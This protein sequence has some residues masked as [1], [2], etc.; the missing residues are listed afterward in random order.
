MTKYD[1]KSEGDPL[2]AKIVDLMNIS[3]PGAGN[4]KFLG[5]REVQYMCGI[6]GNRNPGTATLSMI[7]ARSGAGDVT[8]WVPL[9]PFKELFDDK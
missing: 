8:H 9:N 2:K 6:K 7:Q 1:L 3:F 5:K 4:W